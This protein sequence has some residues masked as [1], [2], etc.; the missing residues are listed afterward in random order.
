MVIL[1]NLSVHLFM[2]LL[3]ANHHTFLKLIE[4]PYEINFFLDEKK[5]EGKMRKKLIK[6]SL[7]YILSKKGITLII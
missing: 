5:K 1:F 7:N 6:F 2:K 3:N 4:T